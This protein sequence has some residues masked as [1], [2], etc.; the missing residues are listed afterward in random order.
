MKT[1]SL[2]SLALTGM[3]LFAIP[4]AEVTADT[5]VNDRTAQSSFKVTATIANGCIL[6]AGATDVS[7]FGALNFGNSIASLNSAIS[8]TS[9]ANAGSIL[10]KCTPNA[11]VT[12]SLDSGLNAASNISAGRL[13]KNSTTN[14]TLNYQLYQN[15]SY[16]TVWGN[17]SNGG[18]SMVVTANGTAQE[19]KVYAR[20]FAVSPVPPA[21]LYT[22]RITVTVTY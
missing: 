11:T 10:I 9:T 19:Y 18:N 15:A 1:Y 2:S 20:L 6:G 3:L 13:L 22:D 12:L 8:I 21:G 4:L 16:S 14:Q 5:G 17:G 7:S